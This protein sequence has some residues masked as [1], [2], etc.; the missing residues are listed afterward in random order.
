MLVIPA[1]LSLKK[2][3][4]RSKS[5]DIVKL[6]DMVANKLFDPSEIVQKTAK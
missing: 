6:V 1:L 3:A 4:M 5:K 2:T